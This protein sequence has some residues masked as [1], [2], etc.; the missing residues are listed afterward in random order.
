MRALLLLPLM[1]T[2]TA[3]GGNS[4]PTAPPAEPAAATPEP[5]AATPAPA[6]AT[7]MPHV[8]LNVGVTRTVLVFSE[9]KDL[10][11]ERF[12]ADLQ[13]AEAKEWPAAGIWL[14][15]MEGVAAAMGGSPERWV[16]TLSFHNKADAESFAKANGI[17]ALSIV[18]DTIEPCGD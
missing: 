7:P 4:K 2:L 5:A 3:C 18:E 17:T 14:G 6:V 11:D 15:C 12:K 16:A 1:L 9:A 13:A 10:E 8:E